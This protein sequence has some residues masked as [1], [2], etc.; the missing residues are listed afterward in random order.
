MRMSFNLTV[1]CIGRNSAVEEEGF[2]ILEHVLLEDLTHCQAGFILL[3]VFVPKSPNIVKKVIDFP[4][5]SRNSLTKLF[6]AGKN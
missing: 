4:V 1:P 5:S 6:L 3:A 2:C